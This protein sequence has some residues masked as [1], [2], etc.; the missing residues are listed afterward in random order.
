MPQSE[1]LIARLLYVHKRN[2]PLDDRI[3][4]EA[5]DHITAQDAEIARLTAALAEAHS[6]CEDQARLNGMGSERE[7][8]LL[9]RLAE[10]QRVP[11]GWREAITDAIGIMD[12]C[13]RAVPERSYALWDVEW[14]VLRRTLYY[15]LAAAPQPP[16]QTQDPQHEQR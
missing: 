7:A 1:D 9:A 6:E 8:R 3:A 2:L 13:G 11:A 4:A 12:D 10:A 16:A 5:A 15:A 14:R